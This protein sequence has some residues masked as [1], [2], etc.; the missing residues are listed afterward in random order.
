MSAGESN[1]SANN[2]SGHSASDPAGVAASIRQVVRDV[3]GFPRPGV[4]FKDI[5]PVLLDAELFMRAVAALAQ[6]FASE[7]ITHVVAVE[8]R[9]F[10]FGAPVALS[11]GA[12]FVP[13][14]KP[15]KLPGVTLRES[16]ALEYGSDALEL[17]ADA[18]V[19]A[20]GILVV[21][22]L[23]AT[24]GTAGAACRLVQRA[25]GRVT[26]CT[27]LIELAALDGRQSLGGTRVEALVVY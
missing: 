7:D 24:G 21:D 26:A 22:D 17:Q 15:G 13:V 25:G 12:S 14:R 16:Y 9:G 10:I 5:T 20:R 18:L 19:E 4:V 6:P 3:P 8:S 1:A 27:F 23:L 11:L 2:A